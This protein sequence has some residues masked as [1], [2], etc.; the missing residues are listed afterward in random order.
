MKYEV[1]EVKERGKF[2][3]FGVFRVGEKKPLQV[4][5]VD[6]KTD[7]RVAHYVALLAC[8]DFEEGIE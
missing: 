5:R 3:G 1:K 2:V 6:K 7:E 4:H 8:R